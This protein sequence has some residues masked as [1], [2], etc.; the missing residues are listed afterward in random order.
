MKRFILICLCAV[1]LCG[2]CI[3][4]LGADVDSQ[5]R[6]LIVQDYGHLTN[7]CVFAEE[8]REMGQ[9]PGTPVE[10]S[11]D[12][13]I[14]TIK[15]S[16]K[17]VVISGE[18]ADGDRVDTGHIRLEDNGKDV[19]VCFWP[20]IGAKEFYDEEPTDQL[21]Q[22]FYDLGLS[23]DYRIT[24]ND[25]CL[26]LWQTDGKQDVM[27]EVEPGVFRKS[28]YN[29]EPGTY[30]FQVLQSGHLESTDDENDDDVYAF[31]VMQTSAVSVELD[32]R[33][34]VDVVNI[35]GP[36]VV[37]LSSVTNTPKPT[38]PDAGNDPAGLIIN[39]SHSLPLFLFGLLAVCAYLIF[40][41][42]RRNRY[43]GEITPEGKVRRRTRLTNQT[44]TNAVKETVP[45]PSDELD[46]ILWESIRKVK[47]A[48]PDQK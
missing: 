35:H 25:D 11:G 43:T 6:T 28:Y 40:L 46:G 44:V 19:T 41:L 48:P 5:Y 4:A 24:G 1:L 23:S 15:S 31:V 20:N 38:E 47:E 37:R 9:W 34:E 36:E 13:Y 21:A 12:F 3:P 29:V 14:I 33:G 17:T 18:N 27:N 45:T 2:L 32:T 8:P 30:S 7:V 16:I 39:P 42:Q 26:N 10:R 22:F